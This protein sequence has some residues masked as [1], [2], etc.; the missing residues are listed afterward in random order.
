MPV[1][2]N[3]ALKLLQQLISTPSFSKEEGPTAATLQS[4]MQALGWTTHRSG[5]NVWTEHIVD[6]NAPTVL[7]NSHHDTV[8]PASGY[9]RDPFDPCIEE[10]RL[11]G[12]GS[13]DAGGCLVG[14]LAAFS[15]LREQHLPIN[16]IFAATAEEEISGVNGIASIRSQLPK[17]DFAIVG[18]PTN[19]AA[20]IAEKGLMVLD[21]KVKGKAGHAARDEG[22]NAIVEAMNVVNALKELSWENESEQLGR[23]KTTVTQIQAGTQ[24]N[25]IPDEC[26]LV[27]DVRTTDAYTNEQ[28]L[29]RIAAHLSAEVTPRSTRLQ[30]SGLDQQHPAIAVAKRLQLRCY[31]SDALSDQALLLC[32]SIKMGPGDPYRSHQADEYLYIHEL[33]KGI[34][35]YVQFIQTLAHDL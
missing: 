28:V 21:I 13:N 29:E 24:H 34:A 14:L 7:L 35:Q 27:V 22:P 12:L 3:S 9:T 20:A 5:N 33:E 6:H 11:Y 31:G 2:C 8:R 25:V 1:T 15:I 26:H 32:P 16:L 18:E 17:L 30:P 4:F 19:L 23:V 10:G